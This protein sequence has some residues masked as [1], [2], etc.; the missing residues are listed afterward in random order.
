[1]AFYSPSPDDLLRWLDE[2]G[3]RYAV[4]R[5]SDALRDG[6]PLDD[7][8]LLIA[9]DAIPAVR[10]RCGKRRR[11]LK[12]DL[13]GV[14]GAHGS[15][16]HGFAHLPEPLGE[17]IL[18][19]RRC[20]DGRF[21]APAPPDELSALLYHLAYHKNLQSGIHWNDPAKSTDSPARYVLERL[22]TETGVHLALTHQA[23]HR[24]LLAEGCAVTGARLVRYIQHDFR[25]AR[26]VY[27]HA[28]LRDELPGELNLFV[29]RGIAVKHARDAELL[30]F[31]AKRFRIL[32]AVPVPWLVRLRSARHMRGGKWR[33][34]G[35][36]H[37][38]VAIFDPH[39]QQATD[40]DRAVHPFVFNRNQFIKLEWRDWFNRNTS[41]REKDNPVHSTDNEAEAIG[42]LP[43]FFSDE[44]QQTILRML[45]DL[46]AGID[47]ASE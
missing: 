1:M 34:G 28:L 41:A 4:L 6:A 20:I 7:L 42:H 18:E 10:A 12:V 30:E 29:V 3:I 46:R 5:G 31:L 2:Q 32:M 22:F 44:Q 8:D 9:D 33:R 23:F 24:H 37:I 43:L 47:P 13:Y 38:A 14:H 19:R 45:A 15:D 27:F 36:P 17:R 35:R 16:Y 40:E 39:P 26:K 25:H 21:Y 11:G